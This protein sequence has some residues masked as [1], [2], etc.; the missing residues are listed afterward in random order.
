MRGVEH[1]AELVL[2]QIKDVLDAYAERDAAK[3]LAVWQRRRGDRRALHRAVPRAAHL[4]DGR[5][6]Q[7]HALHPSAVLAKNIERIGDHATNIAET[8]YYMVDG[9]PSADERPKGDNTMPRRACR[10]TRERRTRARCRD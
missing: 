9:K 10:V 1:M 6:A 7:H 8:V 2:T 4:H 5:P 3:A